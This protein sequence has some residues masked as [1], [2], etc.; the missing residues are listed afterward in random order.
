M[1]NPIMTT[2][3]PTIVGMGVVSRTTETVLGGKRR[4][5]SGGRAR[6]NMPPATKVFHRMRYKFY[7]A[8][9]SKARATQFADRIRNSGKSVRTAKVGGLYCIYVR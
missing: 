3:L 1:V 2:T 7:A 6:S 4:R 9:T 5:S 8:D